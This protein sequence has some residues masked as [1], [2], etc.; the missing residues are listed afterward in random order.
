MKALN[1]MGYKEVEVH[2]EAQQ[3]VGYHGDLRAQ[4]ANIIVRRKFIGHAANDL[5]FVKSAD[6]TYSAIISDFDLGKHNDRWQ[7]DL[8]KNYT[9]AVGRKTAKANGLVF[10]GMKKDAKTGRIQL[11][12]QDLKTR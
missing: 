11:K 6:G 12:F 10:L 1:E 7:K 9:E 8:K 4:K 2:E 5:G 3:L